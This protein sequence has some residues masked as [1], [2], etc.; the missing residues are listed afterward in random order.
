M[1]TWSQRDSNSGRYTHVTTGAMFSQ[2][3]LAGAGNV[4]YPRLLRPKGEGVMGDRD[5]TGLFQWKAAASTEKQGTTEY[6]R[7]LFAPAAVSHGGV[8]RWAY[9][10]L[11]AEAPGPTWDLFERLPLLTEN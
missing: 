6:L 11:K 9:S 10:D 7:A 4:Q 2:P 3:I 5:R 1:P 8:R